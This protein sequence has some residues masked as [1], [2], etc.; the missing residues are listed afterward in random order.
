MLSAVK[1]RFYKYLLLFLPL[2]YLAVIALAGLILALIIPRVFSSVKKIIQSSALTRLD[3]FRSRTN[4]LLLGTGGSTH[5]GAD[6]TDS[7][8]LISIN[9]STADTVIISLPRD[10]WVESLSAKL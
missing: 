9:L 2:I 10:I 7:I 4:I 1:R 5:P 6:L 3:S 8:M